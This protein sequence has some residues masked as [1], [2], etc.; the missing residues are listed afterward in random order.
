MKYK[1]LIREAILLIISTIPIL[2]LWQI[3]NLL[4]TEIPLHY[5]FKGEADSFGHKQTLLWF[6][7]LTI[8]GIYVLLLIIPF[9]DPKKR[10]AHEG[11]SF[12]SIRLI[13]SMF[14]SA[15]FIGYLLELKNRTGFSDFISIIILAFIV[16]FG[17]YMP[18]LKPNYFVGIRTPWTLEHP[19]V[20]SKTHRFS[21]R[22][23]MI[24]GIIL[25][26]IYAIFYNR[27][28]P[29]LAI[30]AIISLAFISVIYSFIAYKKLNVKMG[31]GNE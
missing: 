15:V 24:V 26:I 4:P 28:T 21:G 20:W 16:T 23:W 9:V 6:L 22:L 25:L 19:E 18:R 8:L 12:Y 31:T 11:S 17:N 2:I 14:L 3:W 27:L 5:N 30:I 1:T 29:A 10:I 7:P 13:V